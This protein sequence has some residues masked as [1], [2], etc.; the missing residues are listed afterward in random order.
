MEKS[1]VFPV[2]FGVNIG[3]MRY[4]Q[5]KPRSFPREINGKMWENFVD[6]VDNLV[7][8]SFL[9]ENQGKWMWMYFS[10]ILWITW[11]SCE[12]NIVFVQPDRFTII[13][14][15]CRLFIYYYWGSKFFVNKGPKTWINQG[16]V[17]QYQRLTY[18]S[19]NETDETKKV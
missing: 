5:R 11:I 2:F 8:N 3:F 18:N 10:W 16:M 15:L 1:S 12:S 19:R 14:L 4:E 17:V 13:L 7:H 9:A 6:N